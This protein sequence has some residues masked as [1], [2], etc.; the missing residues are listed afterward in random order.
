[1]TSAFNYLTLRLSTLF[2]LTDKINQTTN[3]DNTLRFV[4]EE[5]PV[6]LPL[7]WVGVLRTTHNTHSYHLDRAYTE[8]SI[9]IVIISRKSI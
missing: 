2:R 8:Q 4:Y 6:F 7:D 1:M 9:Y 5:F 3:L